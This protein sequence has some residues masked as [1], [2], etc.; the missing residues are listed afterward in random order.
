M[1][2]L[3]GVCVLG[4]AVLGGI[5]AVR[6]ARSEPGTGPIHGP[7]AS[8]LAQLLKVGD[9]FSVGSVALENEGSRPGRVERIRLLGVTGPLEPLG[10]RTRREPDPAGDFLG[11]PGFPPP[12][13]PAVPLQR[14]S[15]VPVPTDRTEGGSAL[16]RLQLL[17][18]VRA[19][20]PGVGRYR[21]VEVT[22]SVGGR[23]YRRIMENAAYLCATTAP[24]INP[25]D[26]CPT[27]ETAGKFDDRVIDVTAILK[28]P[29]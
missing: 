19:T 15:V 12:E 22:Y 1:K 5:A 11:F 28:A 14:D 26:P 13:Y 3:I 24:Q 6:A 23:R 25:T 29:S 27:P 17:I 21:A 2:R 20:A 8:T 9:D 18:G 10:V 16:Q 4:V 7:L